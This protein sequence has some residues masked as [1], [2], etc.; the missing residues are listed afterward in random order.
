M[1]RLKSSFV[2]KM[3]NTRDHAPI[4]E[5]LEAAGVEVREKVVVRASDV[6]SPTP[7]T[8]SLEVVDID[9]TSTGSTPE[10]SPSLS[11]TTTASVAE[12]IPTTGPSNLSK[13]EDDELESIVPGPTPTLIIENTEDWMVRRS[14][15]LTRI[16]E[17]KEARRRGCVV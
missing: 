15:S 12:E 13:E 6:R 9:L 1:N 2:H 5:V 3:Q 7:S 8:P 17:K 10:P 14:N 16:K 4:V 11:S